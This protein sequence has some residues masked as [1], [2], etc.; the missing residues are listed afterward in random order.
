MPAIQSFI[1]FCLI[2]S[3]I[4]LVNDSIDKKHDKKHPKKKFRIIASGK[5][6]IR[7]AITLSIL[8]SSISFLISFNLNIYLGSIILLYYITQISYC[9]YLKNI[10]I[11]EFFCIAVGFII[12]SIAGGVASST[13]ISYWFILSI[14][15]LSLYLAIEKRKAEIINTRNSELVTRK[16]LKSYSLSIMNKF[17][18]IFTSCLVMTYSLWSFGPMI[19]GSKSQLMMI[20]IPPVLVGI[21]RYQ[22]LS[23]NFH[24]SKD[25]NYLENPEKVIFIDKPIQITVLSWLFIT[26]AIGFLT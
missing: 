8:L 25:Y 18:T 5:I 21:L 6:S 15:L 24:N 12:R 4:Y 22:M 20:T 2:S 14:G 19:G 13:I 16:V 17:E 10:P 7:T 23:D 11:I 3:S 26:V 1:A 9:F